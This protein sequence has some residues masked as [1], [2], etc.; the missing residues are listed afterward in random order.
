MRR[1]DDWALP[2]GYLVK[3]VSTEQPSTFLE[4]VALSTISDVRT[5]I[6]LYSRAIELVDIRVVYL[7][8]GTNSLMS[9]MRGLVCK[10]HGLGV[11]YE[12]LLYVINAQPI[13]FSAITFGETRR[14]LSDAVTSASGVREQIY[15]TL[16]ELGPV[17]LPPVHPNT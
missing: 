16:A 11:T 14:W 13:D 7:F 5:P 9:V 3:I 2:L 12:K 1:F 6:P 8:N 10:M 17:R 4:T 15:R